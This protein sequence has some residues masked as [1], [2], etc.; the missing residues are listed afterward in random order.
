MNFSSDNAYGVAP[1]ILEALQEANLGAAGGYGDDELTARLQTEMSRVFERDVIAFPV[2][3]GTA[4][5]ALA[6]GTLVPPHG[7]IF[8]H[9]EAHIAV[10]ECGA[11]AF[12]T[13]GARLAPIK[14]GGGKLDPCS[15]EEEISRFGKGVVHHSQPAAISITEATEFGTCYRV[16]EIEALAALAKRHGLKLH[17]DGARFANAIAYLGCTPA[18]ATWRAGVDVL[19]FGATKNGALGADAVV[20][21]HQE[22]TRDFEYRR[23]KS[24]HLI[25]KMRFVSAQLVCALEEGRWLARAAHAN[26]LARLLAGELAGTA[27][28]EVAHA[29]EANSVFAYLPDETIVRLRARGARFYDWGQSSGGR[30]LVRLVT[31]FATCE[32]DIERFVAVVRPELV[33]SGR[34]A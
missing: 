12:F 3:T 15:V 22:D 26:A 14:G 29:V 8:C 30:T 21:F 23:K 17:M 16:R 33:K 32:T 9:S 18:D 2:V 6:L 13:H 19:S 31:S 1:E 34:G 4:A 24:G 20:F 28:V 5:N 7:A 25:S 27:G 11:P 10:D